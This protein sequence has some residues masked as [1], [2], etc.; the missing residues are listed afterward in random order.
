MDLATYELRRS[1]GLGLSYAVSNRGGCHLNGDYMIIVE[2]LNLDVDAQM[3]KAKAD[4]TVIF[5]DKDDPSAKVPPGKRKDTYYA[6][7]G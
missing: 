3:P 4:F 6:A 7:R 2:G 1:V 5:Q